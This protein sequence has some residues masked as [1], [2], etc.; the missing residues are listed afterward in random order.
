MLAIPPFVQHSSSLSLLPRS[1]FRTHFLIHSRLGLVFKVFLSLL[2]FFLSTRTYL[3][4]MLHFLF[5][6]LCY[7]AFRLLPSAGLCRRFSLRLPD[8]AAASALP[9]LPYLAYLVTSGYWL[10]TSA[11]CRDIIAK[12]RSN[13]TRG[14]R[15]YM[16]LWAQDMAPVIADMQ[17][18]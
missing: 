5:I 7:L 13:S 2:F 11:P 1:S 18:I 3:T 10:R 9:S 15:R 14:I 8:S 17:L 4:V 16:G 12:W 6:G